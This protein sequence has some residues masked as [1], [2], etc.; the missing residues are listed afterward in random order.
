MDEETE[1][2]DIERLTNF[3]K[4][5][6]L[7]GWQ[8]LTERSR[9]L[10]RISAEAF[11]LFMAQTES[12]LYRATAKTILQKR[13]R[14]W[15]IKRLKET[16]EDGEKT[17]G[18]IKE[19]TLTNIELLVISSAKVVLQEKLRKIPV[20]KIDRIQRRT[21][22]Q[23]LE[24]IISVVKNEKEIIQAARKELDLAPLL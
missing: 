9:I 2:K 17:K 24:M 15:S 22:S 20:E 12:D 5:E 4:L 18:P 7:G 16:I 3:V 11:A 10:S 23:D 8:S 6:I 14:E 21:K 13:M 1:R 19:A